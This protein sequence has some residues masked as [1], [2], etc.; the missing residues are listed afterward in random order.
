MVK[1]MFLLLIAVDVVLNLLS[2][3]DYT[4]ENLY[5]CGKD[6]ESGGDNT[7]AKHDNEST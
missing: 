3:Y 7:H 5:V 4:T 6:R 1:V 2:T